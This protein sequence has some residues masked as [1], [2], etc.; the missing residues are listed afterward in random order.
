MHE[1]QVI[2][3]ELKEIGENQLCVTDPDA[4]SM[5]NNGKMKFISMFKLQW[6]ANIN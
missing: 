6:T 5:K 1:L 4:K 3:E 2:K